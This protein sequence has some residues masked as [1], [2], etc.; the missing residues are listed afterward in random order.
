MSHI[1]FYIP[2]NLTIPT[3]LRDNIDIY[4]KP[5]DKG[6][7]FEFTIYDV[8]SDEE[9]MEIVKEIIDIMERENDESSWRTVSLELIKSNWDFYKTVIW[10][11]RV[12]WRLLLK[13]KRVKN[14][15]DRINTCI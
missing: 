13:I 7:G 9:A 10:K 4:Y 11:Y 2:K 6:F 12:N 14:A 15:I 5:I 1:K 8:N 3:E